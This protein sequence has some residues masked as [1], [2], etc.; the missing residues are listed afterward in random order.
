MAEPRAEP[1]GRSRKL[2]RHVRARFA[3]AFWTGIANA[4]PRAAL[5]LAGLYVAH[6]FGPDGFARYSLAIVTITVAGG[7]F[8]MAL[9]AIGSKY[10][11]E[12]AAAHGGRRGAGFASVLGF[13][14]ALAVLLAA[15][16]Y[17][18]AT[19]LAVLLAHPDS[20]AQTLRLA[21]PVV[22][23]V[24]VYGAV[25]GLLIGSARFAAAAWTT[26]AGTAVFALTLVALTD[27]L[28]L[29]GALVALG[30]LWGVTAL[31]QLATIGGAI[32]DDFRRSTRGERLAQWKPVAGF[33]VPML[34]FIAMAPAM[35]WI[36]NAILARGDAPLPAVARFNAAYNWFAVAAF[37]PNVLAQV[38]FVHLSRAKARGDTAG[39]KPILRLAMAQNLLVMLPLA[40]LGFALSG[41]LMGLFRV[42]DI[43]GRTTL[44]LMLAAAL[45]ASLSNPTG[46]YFA[47]IDRIW[48][49]T[50]LNVGWGVVALGL[51][52][53]LRDHGAVGMGVAFLAAFVVHLACAATLA[54]RLKAPGSARQDARTPRTH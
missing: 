43:D 48:L 53:A 49:A 18:L 1:G 35:V 24:V 36:C 44:L 20:L 46:V 32:A 14:A 37:L 45:V 34:L 54:L 26:L 22:L 11:P 30:L 10:V 42:D 6:R 33:L 29:A 40:A 47:V 52:W 12:L 3:S 31:C 38:E 50:G 8:S 25:D 51:A 2:A 5:L 27:R 16:L 39:L 7:I 28:D 4:L 13:G 15:G 9:I 41:P 17:V 21:A 23:A 19:P